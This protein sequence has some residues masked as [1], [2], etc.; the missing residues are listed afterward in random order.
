LITP[1]GWL[2]VV[3]VNYPLTLRIQVFSLSAKIE[4]ADA[5]HQPICFVRKN[6]FKFREHITILSGS[7]P[8]SPLC[9]IKAEPSSG[10][11]VRYSFCDTQGKNFGG[12]ARAASGSQLLYLVQNENGN[13]IFEIL[14]RNPRTRSLD[15]MLAKIPLMRLFSTFF[16]RPAFS[17][18][19][20]DHAEFFL[21]Q[22]QAA[23]LETRYS[24]R[25][26]EG[27]NPLSQQEESRLL[28]A[29]LMAVFLEG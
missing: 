12:L 27:F 5:L 15:Q 8:R 3:F 6:R 29:V 1:P 18:R 9:E 14:P 22:K 13:P 17:I 10:Y 2:P 21:L 11:A 28:M 16:L 26:S 19:S 20:L 24:L 4:V 7:P 23:P 25:P